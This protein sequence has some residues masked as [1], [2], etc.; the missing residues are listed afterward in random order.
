[1]N[2]RLDGQD[3][4]ATLRASCAA[5]GSSVE[6]GH[7]IPS[8]DVAADVPANSEVTGEKCWLSSVVGAPIGARENWP[9]AAFRLNVIT[10]M[11]H[12]CHALHQ[13]GWGNRR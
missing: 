9:P 10:S 4:E 6:R 5:Y 11:P 1:M 2:N 7:V 8:G 3:P 13:I 12:R